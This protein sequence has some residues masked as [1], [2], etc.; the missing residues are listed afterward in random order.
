MATHRELTAADCNGTVNVLS[1]DRDRLAVCATCG[2]VLAARLDQARVT[3]QADPVACGIT[4]TLVRPGA[5]LAI[6]DCVLSWTSASQVT[7]G[8]G[9]ARSDDD[10]DQIDVTSPIVVD[11]TVAGDNGLDTGAEASSTWYFVWL[12]KDPVTGTV[13]GRLS[14]SASSPTVPAGRVKRRVGFVRN[15]VGSNFNDFRQTGRGNYHWYTTNQA[16]TSI[17]PLNG[18]TA[19]AW[20]SIGL[21]AYCPST[22]EYGHFSVNCNAVAGCDFRQTGASAVTTQNRCSPN[23]AS[24]VHLPIV[25]QSID[26]QNTGA[27]GSTDVFLVEYRETI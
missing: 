17:R 16:A 19:T 22:V 27:G 2:A 24:R 14:T 5:S 20:T 3:D 6:E 7:I 18:G 15:N 4:P 12:T 8:T 25:S 10:T 9:W 11:I 13:T 26:Y 1:R 21:S 23:V